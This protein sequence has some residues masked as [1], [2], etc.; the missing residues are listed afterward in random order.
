LLSSSL[1]CV[2]TDLSVA[3]RR[4]AFEIGRQRSY[5][6]PLLEKPPAI[7]KMLEL[8]WQDVKDARSLQP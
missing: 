7:R 2:E 3:S 4:A 6:N 5:D 8:R 1:W